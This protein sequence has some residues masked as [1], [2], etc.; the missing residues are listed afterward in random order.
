MT[1]ST[2]AP[3]HFSLNDVY[4]CPI[5]RFGQISGLPLMDALACNLCSHIF[6][7]DDACKLLTLAGHLSPL[8]WQWDGRTWHAPHTQGLGWG[9]KLAAVALLVLPTALILLTAYAFRPVPNGPPD[10]FPLFWAALTF[11]CHLFGILGILISY[12][13]FSIPSYLRAVRRHL[14]NRFAWGR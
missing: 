4:H 12:Y 5:C 10:A 1:S 7:A 6:L 3:Q 8:T 9:D 11:I 14:Q 13:Q 2:Y